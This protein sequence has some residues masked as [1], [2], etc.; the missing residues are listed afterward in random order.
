M[1]ILTCAIKKQCSWFLGQALRKEYTVNG[2]SHSQVNLPLKP[3][4]NPE[5][6]SLAQIGLKLTIPVTQA[7]DARITDMCHMS[8]PLFS[9]D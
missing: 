3:F 9:K 5:F 6:C 4:K 1:C 2:V 7:T 8:G